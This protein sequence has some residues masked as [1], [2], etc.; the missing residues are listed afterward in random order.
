MKPFRFKK[1]TINQNKEVFRVGT[2]GV[3]LGALAKVEDAGNI[4]EVG[5]GS[6]LISLMIAQRNPKATISFLDINVEAVNLATENFHNSP[7]N[8]RI[9]AFHGDFKEFKSEKRFD[10]IIS[11]PPYFE[12]NPSEKDFLARQQRELSFDELIQKSTQLL[13]PAGRF[14]VIIPSPS[15]EYFKNKCIES[16]LLLENQINIFGIK[17]GHL[18]RL[19]LE[20]SFKKKESTESDFIIEDSPRVYSTQ[21]LEATTDFHL[22]NEKG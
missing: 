8:N 19:I 10:L 17:D 9:R 7:F 22:F 14:S 12:P 2:D 21:Y 5:T 13:S 11:N 6:G 16:G 18:K 1:F 4:L 15:G 20:F 3:L